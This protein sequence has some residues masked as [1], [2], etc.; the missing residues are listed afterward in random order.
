[1]RSQLAK[2][3]FQNHE[4]LYK[5]YTNYIETYFWKLWKIWTLVS[6]WILLSALHGWHGWGWNLDIDHGWMIAAGQRFLVVACF[7]THLVDTAGIKVESSVC[8]QPGRFAA[9]TFPVC[10]LYT[11]WNQRNIFDTQFFINFLILH[12]FHSQLLLLRLFSAKSKLIVTTSAEAQKKRDVV[13]W[14][15]ISYWH[16]PKNVPENG[17]KTWTKGS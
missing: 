12:W 3:P 13:A 17:S 4:A 14:F 8:L 9:A 5:L 10:R 1:M 7:R 2:E 16:T 6:Q 15:C 11:S